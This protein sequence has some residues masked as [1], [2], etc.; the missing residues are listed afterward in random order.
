MH[1]LKK[2][3]F[4][5]TKEIKSEEEHKLCPRPDGLP[6]SAD[7]MKEEEQAKMP[8]SS[9]TRLLRTMGR[10]PAWYSE[11]PDHETD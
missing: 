8:D 7:E 9:Y 5:L 4:N 1:K 11:V 10:S 3:D 2:N 6:K